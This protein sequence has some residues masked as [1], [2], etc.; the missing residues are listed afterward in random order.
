MIISRSLAYLF[1][2]L[3]CQFISTSVVAGECPDGSTSTL[4][5]TRQL[6]VLEQKLATAYAANEKHLA[7]V[8]G[9]DGYGGVEGRSYLHEAIES[10]R[11]SNEAWRKFRDMECWYLALHDGMNL[12]PDHATPVSEACKVAR[13]NERIKSL[14]K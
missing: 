9:T 10:F 14:T 6:A 1:L 2:A 8:Y 7:E 11:A 12:S 3:T 13:T 5:C 4:E